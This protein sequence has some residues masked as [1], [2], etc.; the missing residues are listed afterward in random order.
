MKPKFFLLV[1]LMSLSCF[2]AAQNDQ[3]QRVQPVDISKP[4]SSR[5]NYSAKGND[6]LRI[7]IANFNIPGLEIISCTNCVV[8]APWTKAGGGLLEVVIKNQGLVKSKAATVWVSYYTTTMGFSWYKSYTLTNY[9]KDQKPISPLDPGKTVKVQFF[10]DFGAAFT[11]KNKG[12]GV[13][14]T[15][16]G[17]GFIRKGTIN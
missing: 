16:S 14:L 17:T 13:Y 6:S 2:I 4:V 12:V 8:D 7:E 11:V 15:Q 1:M 9:T 10:I 5:I 3:P